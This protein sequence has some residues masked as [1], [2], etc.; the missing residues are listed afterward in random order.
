MKSFH[1]YRCVL[2]L[3]VLTRF[4]M[5]V[6]SPVQGVFRPR[7]TPRVF[8]FFEEEEIE[9]A[10]RGISVEVDERNYRARLLARAAVFSVRS[11]AAIS[12]Q[13]GARQRINC[14]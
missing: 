8:K 11:S 2:R 14:R 9:L 3:L 12:S 7:I 5:V 10:F 13:D 4:G 6:M 1:K